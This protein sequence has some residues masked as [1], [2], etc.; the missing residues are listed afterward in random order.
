M[1][2]TEPKHGD[3]VEI[4]WGNRA[5]VRGRV[6]EVYGHSH[7]HVVVILTPVLSDG[8]VSEDTTLSIPVSEVR[9]AASQVS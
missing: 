9:P 8:V 7:R 3:I 2:H 4:P 5:T 6:R 1:K